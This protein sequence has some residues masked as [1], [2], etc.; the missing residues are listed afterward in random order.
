MNFNFYEVLLPIALILSLSKLLE[1]G[2]RKINIPQVIAML[3]AG[4]LIGLVNYIPNQEI[5]LPSGV[6]GIGFIAKIGV[7]LIMYSA[8]L[9]TDVKKIK[10]CGVSSLV[11]TLLGV[12]VPMGL[13]FIVATLFNG[14]FSALSDHKTLMTNL[15]YGT[16]LTAT[17]V[18]VS[19][20]TLKEVNKLDTKVG[21]SIISA[22]ILD[23]ILG[24]IKN[25]C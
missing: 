14:G 4:V 24:I 23:D 2:F 21:T 22:A 3:L 18:S 19:V 17:S 11:I 9:E 15:F 16:I 5:L 1:I 12:V 13:G 10:E 20:A 7:I 25:S 6:A 8:G